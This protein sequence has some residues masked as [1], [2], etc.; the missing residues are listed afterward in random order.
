MQPRPSISDY[1]P[2]QLSHGAR[3]GQRNSSLYSSRWHRKPTQLQDSK[4]VLERCSV[5]GT[6]SV[7]TPRSGWVVCSDRM[8]W[9]GSR[10]SNRPTASQMTSLLQ[11]TKGQILWQ[12]HARHRRSQGCSGCTCTPRR[13]IFF[14]CNSQGNTMT[15]F[16]GTSSALNILVR[17][18]CWTDRNWSFYPVNHLVK[19]KMP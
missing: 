1:R 14:S 16:V 11:L 19:F 10:Y 8:L 17:R 9:P 18:K 5:D 12:L 6:G 4:I 7:F 13:K 2:R 3:P 15:T